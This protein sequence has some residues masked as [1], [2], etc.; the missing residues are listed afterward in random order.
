MAHPFPG[1]EDRAADVEAEAVVLERRA[2]PVAHQEA[3]QAAVGVVELLLAPREAHAGSVRDRQVVRHRGIEADEAM[4]EELDPV[5]VADGRGAA[6]SGASISVVITSE[7]TTADRDGDVPPAVDGRSEGDVASPGRST[8][9]SGEPAPR[10]R[11]G[12]RWGVDGREEQ[13]VVERQHDEPDIERAVRAGSRRRRRRRAGDWR[14]ARGG[15]RARASRP[16]SSSS[17]TF[18]VSMSVRSTHRSTAAAGVRPA[19]GT[20]RPRRG[21]A[22][23]RERR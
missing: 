17:A 14:P 11:R 8:R 2:V 12:R 1:H 9:G 23:E 4:I 5:A 7:S 16:S 10:P 15:R 6:G 3:D 13:A 18:A 22:A 21:S 19:A 20:D